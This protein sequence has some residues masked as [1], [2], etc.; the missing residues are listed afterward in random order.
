MNYS[1]P[2]TRNVGVSP[3]LKIDREKKPT[4]KSNLDYSKGNQTN[5]LIDEQNHRPV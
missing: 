2:T 3:N 1:P 4:L 5:S